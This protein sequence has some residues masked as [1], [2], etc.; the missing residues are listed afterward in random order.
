M[1][2]S[3]RLGGGGG[4]GKAEVTLTW[5][6]SPVQ[7]IPVQRDAGGEECQQGCMPGDLP[8]PPWLW[9]RHC[10]KLC[11]AKGKRLD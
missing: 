10:L 1:Q 2:V 11:E 5:K 6:D 3:A 4:Q 8:L 7:G 9:H